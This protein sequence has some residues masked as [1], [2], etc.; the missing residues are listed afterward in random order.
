MCKQH[1]A[2]ERKKKNK[3]ERHKIDWITYYPMFC[4][5]LHEG[6]KITLNPL[7]FKPI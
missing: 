5:E 1:Q 7:G 6:I 2:K 4:A 3:N